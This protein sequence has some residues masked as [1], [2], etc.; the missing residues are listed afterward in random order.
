MK[1]S[2]LFVALAAGMLAHGVLA[3]EVRAPD[4]N[5]ERAALHVRAQKAEAS[6]RTIKERKA[7]K[8]HS[9]SSHKDGSERPDMEMPQLG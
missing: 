4:R 7:V 3:Q 6:P 5:D 1:L 8:A 9:K 2:K